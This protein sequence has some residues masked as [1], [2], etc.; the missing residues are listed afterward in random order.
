M[1]AAQPALTGAHDESGLA[2]RYAR[3]LLD[4]LGRA[5]P[6]AVA[7]S[8]PADAAAE[9]GLEVL[10]GAAEAPGRICP[11][12]IAACADGALGGYR[13]GASRKATMLGWEQAR[14][15]IGASA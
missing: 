6:V 12:P 5:E 3:G 8:H 9:C 11:A 2:A 15:E 10:T 7:A 13:W 1:G 14:S 4:G